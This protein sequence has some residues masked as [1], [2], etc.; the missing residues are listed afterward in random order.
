M[1]TL[2]A[3]RAAIS[4]PDPYTQ[5]DRLVR[6][7]MSAGRKVKEIFDAIHP[8]TGLRGREPRRGS[9]YV[10][11]PVTEDTPRITSLN[12]SHT[13]LCVSLVTSLSS[14]NSVSGTGRD[15]EYPLI[16][17]ATLTSEENCVC[18]KNRDVV[19][20]LFV[21]VG[22]YRHKCFVGRVMSLFEVCSRGQVVAVLLHRL[23]CGSTSL[24]IQPLPNMT[25]TGRGEEPQFPLARLALQ[26]VQHGFRIG[27]RQPFRLAHRSAPGDVGRSYP[28]RVYDRQ[29][30]K[31]SRRLGSYGR[32]DH[33][34]RPPSPP[35]KCESIPLT[36]ART[37]IRPGMGLPLCISQ[38]GSKHTSGILIAR[39]ASRNR[40]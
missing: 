38:T 10:V 35:A 20:A 30:W 12:G 24:V 40:S 1:I 23:C 34:A 6:E 37:T 32:I 3:I 36:G 29:A 19:P 21:R 9:G 7:E 14:R 13:F 8:L 5:M 2:D 15:S 39:D 27:T 31:E 22:Q 4:A 28:G 33:P 25:Q 11:E 16:V 18:R 17:K 26:E